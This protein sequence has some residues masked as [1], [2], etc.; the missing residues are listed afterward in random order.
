MDAMD[1]PCVSATITRAGA[2]PSGSEEPREL[3]G[4]SL[5]PVEPP[6]SH[7]S[8]HQGA[9][10]VS[11]AFPPAA[12]TRTSPV[13]IAPLPIQD[14][15]CLLSM[16]PRALRPRI[17]RLSGGHASLSSDRDPRVQLAPE[18][19]IAASA[20]VGGLELVQLCAV[21]VLADEP[22]LEGASNGVVGPEIHGGNLQPTGKGPAIPLVVACSPR[23]GVM[24]APPQCDRGPADLQAEADE[25]RIHCTDSI[26]EG[27]HLWA[28][29]LTRCR[30]SGPGPSI[31]FGADPLC[32]PICG[33]ASTPQ[34]WA[35]RQCPESHG[36]RVVGLTPAGAMSGDC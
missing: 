21:V 6:S 32:P 16:T 35:A 27:L 3:Q 12:G 26:G 7:L 4:H 23:S 25:D 18:R 36:P 10:R 20:H 30:E 19:V 2:P 5:A 14:G 31:P 9:T 28:P 24:I 22:Q 33:G 29:T 17:P 15:D 34:R 13:P 11:R 1:T 8:S